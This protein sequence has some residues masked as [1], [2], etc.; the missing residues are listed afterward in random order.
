[1]GFQSIR[2][3]L[4]IYNDGIKIAT[5]YRSLGHKFIPWHAIKEIELY[6]RGRIGSRYDSRTYYEIY[7]F[8]KNQ[9]KSL[10]ISELWVENIETAYNLIKKHIK[11]LQKTENCQNHP[12]IKTVEQCRTCGA[13]FCEKC[14]E[15]KSIEGFKFCEC[16]LCIYNVGLNRIKK[17]YFFSL[18]CPLIFLISIILKL[19]INLENDLT[20]NLYIISFILSLPFAF[21][22]TP[23][24]YGFYFANVKRKEILE[25][26]NIRFDQYSL[27]KLKFFVILIN[28]INPIFYFCF[29]YL[30]YPSSHIILSSIFMSIYLI[31]TI[32]FTKISYNIEKPKKTEEW[33][34]PLERLICSNCGEIFTLKSDYCSC[35]GSKIDITQPTH[36]ENRKFKSFKCYNIIIEKETHNELI[37]VKDNRNSAE[38]SSKTEMKCIIVLLIPVLFIILFSFSLE[39][40]Q[41][42]VLLIFPLPILIFFLIVYF[43]ERIEINK[44]QKLTIDK[45]N[46]K[47]TY[48]KNSLDPTKKI[49][50]YDINTLKVIE[51]KDYRQ[52]INEIRLIFSIN[53]LKLFGIMRKNNIIPIYKKLS[54]YLEIPIIGTEGKKVIDLNEEKLYTDSIC[55]LYCGFNNLINDKIQYCMKCGEKIYK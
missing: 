11:P 17:C 15:K 47:I 34:T 6:Y 45:K 55:C 48:Y 27:K 38:K 10:K 1:M 14:I 18:I 35:C 25:Q 43:F 44:V 52:I 46:Q 33:S 49:E 39:A 2:T 13:Y 28:L 30:L 19:L 42:L 54:S 22:T 40:L 31:L 32:I 41:F 50:I 3:F 20:L 36:R 53:E 5:P 7:I 16:S 24:G 8:I 21:I 4:I 12:K 9:P 29:F 23:H 26:L 51:I 37:L